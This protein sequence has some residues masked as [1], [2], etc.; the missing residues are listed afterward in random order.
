MVNTRENNPGFGDYTSDIAYTIDDN[1]KILWDFRYAQ[2]FFW[3][4]I[5]LHLN[6]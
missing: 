3:R 2:R 5:W 1:G 6:R 4:I